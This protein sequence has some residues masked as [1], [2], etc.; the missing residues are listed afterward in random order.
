MFDFRVILKTRGFQKG[1]R[2]TLFPPSS[3]AHNLT[4]RVNIV[5]ADFFLRAVKRRVPVSSGRLRSS[6]RGVFS[7]QSKGQVFNLFSALPY[8]APQDIGFIPHYIPIEYITGGAEG[9]VTNPEYFVVVSKHTPFIAPAYKALFRNLPRL[10][11]KAWAK[12]LQQGNFGK[13]KL[14]ILR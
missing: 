2:V 8:A 6:I 9:P 11:N 13:T 7:R 3:V 1:S 5:M 12:A 4:R 14:E 10:H